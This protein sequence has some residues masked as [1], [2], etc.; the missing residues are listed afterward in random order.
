MNLLLKH[1][2]WTVIGLL[3]L[4]LLP[5]SILLFHKLKDNIHTV[6][7]N[8]VY[9]SAQLTPEKLAKVIE[10]GQLKTI[11]NLRGSTHHEWYR[12]ESALAKSKNVEILSLKLP[13]KGLPTV[14][15]L[16]TLV[17]MIETAPKPFIIHCR[18]GADRTGLASAIALI[19][20][21]DAPLPQSNGQIAWW[22]GA[23]F[24]R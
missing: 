10:Q 7:P 20:F 16:K 15:D 1:K 23:I 24:V 9:R 2:K 21:E 11:I 13:P 3:I 19:L 14:A 18:K 22:Y 8:Q 12:H 5:I 17:H 6:I 4:F